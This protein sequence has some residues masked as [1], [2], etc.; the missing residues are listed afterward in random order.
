MWIQICIWTRIRIHEVAVYGSNLDP[1]PPQG[2][3]Y[4]KMGKN[5]QKYFFFLKYCTMLVSILGPCSTCGEPGVSGSNVFPPWAASGR[6]WP[7]A[8]AARLLLTDP[9]LSSPQQ[10]RPCI[11]SNPAVEEQCG[12]S[13]S[14][15]PVISRLPDSI[16]I[17]GKNIWIQICTKR[18][19][20]NHHWQY[21]AARSEPVTFARAK[22]RCSGAKLFTLVH[23]KGIFSI[24]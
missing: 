24:L 6:I 22:S 2:I 8:P 9:S 19:Y 4:L 3:K 10:S 17:T 13:G 14:K 5:I 12:E 7:A 23:D 1:D 15:R 18:I 20:T 21:S 11:F 16:R